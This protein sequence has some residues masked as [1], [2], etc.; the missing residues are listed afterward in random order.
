MEDS[1]RNQIQ[2]AGGES[3]LRVL[4]NGKRRYSPI[5]KTWVVEQCLRLDASLAGIALAHRLNATMLRKWVVQH[6]TSMPAAAPAM[7]LLPVG[8]ARSSKLTSPCASRTW[9]EKAAQALWSI[10]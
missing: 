5:F 10:V 9:P 4:S 7:Q 2:W 8:V 3:V 6:K 1:G